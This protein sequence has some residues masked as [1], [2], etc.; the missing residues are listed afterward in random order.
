MNL[1]IFPELMKH[2]RRI[3][4]SENPY[5]RFPQGERQREHAVVDGEDEFRS[6]DIADQLSRVPRPHDAELLHEP[7]IR[8]DDRDR[9]DR[10]QFPRD[11]MPAVEHPEV[12]VAERRE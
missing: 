11:G 4:G 5:G 6:L 10:L 8:S 9:S 7:F 2:E 3:G 12:V 1:V